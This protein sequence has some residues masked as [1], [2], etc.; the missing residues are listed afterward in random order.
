MSLKILNI[1]CQRSKECSNIAD[2]TEGSYS[3]T[4]TENITGETLYASKYFCGKQNYG[5][6]TEC[7]FSFFFFYFAR[8]RVLSHRYAEKKIKI[9][10]EHL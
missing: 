7:S 9:N 5:S 1:N 4:V 6:E 3:G 10:E 2:K 8:E